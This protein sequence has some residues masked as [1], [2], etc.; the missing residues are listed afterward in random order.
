MQARLHLQDGT[1]LTG[2]SIGS[3]GIGTGELVFSTG[4]VGYPEA[5]TDPSYAKQILVMTYPL[6]GNYGVADPTTWESQKAHIAGLVVSS[7]IDTPSHYTSKQSLA[8][9]LQHEHIPAVEIKDTRILA[10]LMRDGGTM[11]AGIAVGEEMLEQDSLSDP[12]EENLVGA[13]STS[14]PYAEGSGDKTVVLIDCGAKRNI[15][16]ELVARGLR[17]VTVPWDYDFFSR[18]GELVSRSEIQGVVISN[19][20][21]DPQH[22]AVMQHTIPLI[23]RV[24]EEKIP[25]LGICLGNQLL[26]LAAGGERVKLKFGHRSQNQPSALVGTPRCYLTTQNHGFAVS[27]VPDGFKPWFI[28]ANDETNEGII[29]ESLPFMSVQFHPEARPGPTDTSWIF[30]YFIEKL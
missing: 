12:N 19:G 21:G 24:L 9:W 10:K 22:P 15:Q 29:H 2:R 8:A 4:M 28:N 18:V 5:F 3:S 23:Q 1:I 14:K 11:P 16:R 26:A 30:D 6:V 27:R 17:V 13:V 20:P 7:A 25:T